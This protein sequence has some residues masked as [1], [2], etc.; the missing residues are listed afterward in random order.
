M[1][2]RP[3]IVLDT[4]VKEKD[5]KYLIFRIAEE[6][7][8]IEILKVQEIIGMISV[9]KVP[10]MPEFIKGVINLRGKII[11]VV[12]FRLKFGFDEIEYTERTCIIVVQIRRNG[13]D[14]VMGLI[15]DEVSEVEEIKSDQVD[16]APQIGIQ[17]NTEFIDGVGKLEDR[18]VILLNADRVL[19]M[20]ELDQLQSAEDQGNK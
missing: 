20:D 9:T 18:V 5:D 8:G 3:A 14:M 12:D 4:E 17:V 10:R 7:Y 11:P 6:E 2:T 13:A 1:E 15:V 19:N 16:P